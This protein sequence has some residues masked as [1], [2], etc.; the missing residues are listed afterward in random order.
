[1]ALRGWEHLLSE[2]AVWSLNQQHTHEKLLQC[3][4]P[5]T[6]VLGLWQRQEIAGLTDWQPRAE[7]ESSRF[8]G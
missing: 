7:V 1:M 2:H 8:S 3:R 6:G 5:G 4:A